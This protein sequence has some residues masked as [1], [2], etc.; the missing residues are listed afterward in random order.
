MKL[1]KRLGFSEQII[2]TKSVYTLVT[3]KTTKTKIFYKSKMISPLIV[4]SVS[5]AQL[6]AASQWSRS[7][8]FKDA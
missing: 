7:R 3:S 2:C 4:N 8:G 6:T 1:N 5:D